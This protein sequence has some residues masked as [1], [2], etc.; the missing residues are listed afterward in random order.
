MENRAERVFFVSLM[1]FGAFRC[2]G[3]VLDAIS[4]EIYGL[5]RDVCGRAKWVILEN[6]LCQG[7]VD[8]GQG[9]PPIYGEDDE[10]ERQQSALRSSR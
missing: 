9:R 5:D 10:I 8:G 2:N 4:S 7:K 1:L 3:V 6:Y